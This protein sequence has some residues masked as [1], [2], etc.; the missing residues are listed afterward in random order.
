MLNHDCVT[1]V[2]QMQDTARKSADKK[3]ITAMVLLDQKAAY[4]LFDREMLLGKVAAYNFSTAAVFLFRSYLK[5]RTFSGQIESATSE[6]R[7]LVEYGIPQGSVLGYLLFILSQGD[8]PGA[9][10]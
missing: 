3:N 1:A 4:D 9:W 7:T 6:P 10:T 2:S 8:L 5:G